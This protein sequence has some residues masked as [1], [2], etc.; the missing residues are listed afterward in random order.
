VSARPR[1][2]T[3]HLAGEED[4]FAAASEWFG[5]Y[6]KPTEI[7]SFLRFAREIEPRTCCEIG[8]WQAGTLFLLAHLLRSVSLLVGVDT[9]LQNE[10]KLRDL[11]PPRVRLGL[12]EGPSAATETLSRVREILAGEKLD[13]LFVDGDHTYEG[14]STDF[15]A[16]RS[17]VREG[18]IVA[19]HDIVPDYRSR[20]GWRTGPWGGNVPRLWQQ[21]RGLYESVEFVDDLEQNAYGIGAIVFTADTP[22]QPRLR[23]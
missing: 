22:F 10:A 5:L 20:F 13:L 9:L 6:Q 1:S 15:R 7:L 14:V 19:F 12:V 16:Y 21:V 18:G 8:T 4:F 11:V 3:A 23:L 17:F 2:P